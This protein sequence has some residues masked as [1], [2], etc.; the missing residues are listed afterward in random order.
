MSARG[1][2]QHGHVNDAPRPG[3]PYKVSKSLQ[4][5]IEATVYEHPR[6]P[7]RD[8]AEISQTGLSYVTVHKGH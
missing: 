2:A 5:H 8:I 1:L 3:R 7:L 4:K 6:A